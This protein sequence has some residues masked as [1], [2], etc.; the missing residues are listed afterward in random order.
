MTAQLQE[1]FRPS[2]E[3][4]RIL[5]VE[6]EMVNQKILT[7]YLED[8]YTVIPAATGEEAIKI[9]HMQFETISLILLDLNLPDVQAWRFY[10]GSR[11]TRATPACR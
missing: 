5:V 7:R 6:D 4:R 10:S 8:S 11:P 1:A 9:V 2:A 3:R